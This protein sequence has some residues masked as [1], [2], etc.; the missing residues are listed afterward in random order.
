[1][2]TVITRRLE[3]DAGHRLMNHESKCSNVHGHRYV[4]EITV[5]AP[6]LDECGR[7]IDFGVI[8]ADVGGW[9][10]DAWDHGFLFEVGD[11]VGEALGISGGTDGQGR[12][13]KTFPMPCAPSAE[14]M[15]D[16]LFRAASRLLA[17]HDITVTRVRLYETPNCWADCFGV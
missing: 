12:A 9:I 11:P 15:A 14:N 3:F 1:M 4:A 16:W 10:D 13:L 7:V 8:K 6:S 2:S 5:T 17:K